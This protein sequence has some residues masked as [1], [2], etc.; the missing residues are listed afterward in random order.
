M[1]S[2]EMRKL[3]AG[4]LRAAGYDEKTRTLG[5]RADVGPV[6]VHRGSRPRCGDG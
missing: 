3:N 5:R 2:M 1:Q 4:N 6:R